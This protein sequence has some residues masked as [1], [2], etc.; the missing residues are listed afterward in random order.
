MKGDRVT[1]LAQGESAGVGAEGGGVEQQGKGAKRAPG[2]QRKGQGAGKGFVVLCWGKG[3]G[4]FF[5]WGSR[6]RAGERCCCPGGWLAAPRCQ[7]LRSE[8]P[9][10]PRWLVLQV[11]VI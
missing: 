4:F 5:A 1:G 11:Q 6:Q 3:A 7:E 10:R 2:W 9:Q 8:K